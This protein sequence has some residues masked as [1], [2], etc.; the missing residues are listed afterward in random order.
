[1]D[2]QFNV[3]DYWL[4]DEQQ[5]QLKIIL[6]MLRILNNQQCKIV[7][8][9]LNKNDKITCPKICIMGGEQLDEPRVYQYLK[10]LENMNF[11]TSERLNGKMHY[12]LVKTEVADFADCINFI[13]ISAATF[14]DEDTLDLKLI[15]QGVQKNYIL[16]YRLTNYLQACIKCLVFKAQKDLLTSIIKKLYEQGETKKKFLHTTCTDSELVETGQ[17]LTTVTRNLEVLAK[18]KLTVRKK[19]KNLQH[20]SLNVEQ[21]LRIWRFLTDTSHHNFDRKNSDRRIIFPKPFR[22]PPGFRPKGR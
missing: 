2:Q 8:A 11:V 18:R 21:I 12:S 14:A 13:G 6:R 22:L 5:P 7:F 4:G 19:E 9:I 10:K 15:E 17:T 20:N 1:M 3:L 16:D